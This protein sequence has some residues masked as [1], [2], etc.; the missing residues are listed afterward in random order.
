MPLLA[1]LQYKAKADELRGQGS[2][3]LPLSTSV[4]IHVKAGPCWTAC[5]KD[6]QRFLRQDNRGLRP[7]F[8]TL[9]QYCIA[10]TDLVPLITTYPGAWDIVYNA[11]ECIHCNPRCACVASLYKLQPKLSLASTM[12]YGGS[13]L[14][15]VKVAT[16]M[17]MP[18]EPESE[19]H[20]MQVQQRG[21]T[22]FLLASS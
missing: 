18:V 4:D 19:A 17:T 5:L 8:M 10:R 21:P 3:T 12:A 13:P 9:G 22:I 14:Y 11:C 1:H 2:N 15:A 7:A 20:A 6:L 16:F